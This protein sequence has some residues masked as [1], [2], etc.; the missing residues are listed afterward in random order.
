[1]RKAAQVGERRPTLRTPRPIVWRLGVRRLKSASRRRDARK[2]DPTSRPD[3]SRIERLTS[4]EA[5]R[6][7]GARAA[8]TDQLHQGPTWQCRNFLRHCSRHVVLGGPA[9]CS[10]HKILRLK[11][12]ATEHRCD[13]LLTRSSGGATPRSRQ[14]TDSPSP[15]SCDID[16]TPAAQVRLAVH[17][18]CPESGR[19]C[20]APSSNEKRDAA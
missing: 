10:Y 20:G 14:R 3:N 1:M 8:K 16:R 6:V 2:A 15:P 18:I 4:S 12:H 9:K 5:V 19:P 17:N 7:M 13:T 11:S